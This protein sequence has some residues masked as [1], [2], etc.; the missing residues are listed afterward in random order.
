M[1]LLPPPSWISA[2]VALPSL[3]EEQAKALCGHVRIRARDTLRRME[4]A[5]IVA[6]I[7]R[8]SAC[9]L[10]RSHPLRRKAEALLPVVTGYD[11]E[12]V[13]LGLT[14]TLKTFRRPQLLRF[15]AED[16]FNPGVLDG[17]QPAVKGGFVRAQLF[18]HFKAQV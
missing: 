16:F 8:A 3:S 1:R 12:T 2:P 18:G 11:R 14:S 4:T 7:D 17:F 13:R 5:R 10:D 6:A 15:L 9:L